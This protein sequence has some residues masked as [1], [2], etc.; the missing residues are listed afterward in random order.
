ME[1]KERELK[2][3]GQSP[4]RVDA[5]EKVTGRTS[6]AVDL[7]F[8]GMLH[9][10]VVRSPHAHA[11]IVFMDTRKARQTPG[12]VS[13]VTGED[14]PTPT[15]VMVED[16][17]FLARKKVRFIGDPVAAVA[18]VDL[19]AAEEALQ[20]IEVEYE[21]LPALFDPLEAMKPGAVLIHE[22][23]S[24][25]DLAPG[26]FPVAG[27]NICNHFKI[28]KGDVEEGFAK[29]DIVLEDTYKTQMVQHAHLEPHAAIAQV[30]L[31]GRVT[32]WS[33]TQ[34]PYFNR[35]AVARALGLPFNK[36]RLV[37][38]PIG[39]GFGGKI[40]L[41]AEPICVA[42]SLKARGRPVRLVYTREEEFEA[43]TVRHP[44]RIRCKS[45]MKNDGTWLAQETELIFD[46]GAYADIGPR[47]NRSAGL[48][49]TGPYVIPNVKV[50]SYCVY[51]NQPVGGAFR[52]FGIP[53]VTWAAESH[54][55][56]VA[57]ELG[58]D[59]VEIRMRNAVG[60]GSISAT[61]QVFHSVGLKET[62]REAVRSIGWGKDPRP[63]RG[64]GIAC[65]HKPTVTPSSSAAFVKLNEDASVTV[66]CSAVELGQG[67]STTLG[68]IASEELGIPID[69]IYVCPADT[70]T[71][72]YDMATVAS[73]STFFAGN[74]VRQAAADARRQLL[75]IAS[76][77]LKV[78]PEEL[79]VQNGI[80]VHAHDPGIAIP[81]ANLPLGEAYYVGV[82]KKGKGRPILGRG[83]HTVEASTAL[84]RE[85][86]Q[87]KNPSAFWMYATQAAEVEVDPLTGKVKVLRIAAAHDM[88]KAIHPRSCEGQI[89]GG[90]MMGIG[91]TL[92]EEMELEQGKVRNPNFAEYKIPSALDGAEMIPILVEE[93]HR[94]GPYGAKG[95][96]EPA[97]APTAAAIANAIEAAVGVRITTLPITPEKILEGLSKK[98]P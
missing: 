9:A 63:F 73:R 7:T 89:Q 6:F 71:T 52:G 60:E 66:L 81:I 76:G 36:V 69:K 18:A 53:Q 37:V 35:N 23:L 14:I 2:T 20:K 78:K 22:D 49:A 84:D 25:Y 75:D 97:L 54:L 39:G 77:I 83:T 62:I 1:N 16:Q 61:G 21:P 95:L 10:K 32:I 92:F 48:A 65:M 56:R 3:V 26:V 96:G 98:C 55:D 94:D 47:V 59:P 34:S 13:V 70:D 31:A 4:V 57:R 93:P 64:K 87:G 79:R 85:T 12:V 74:A 80:V 86:G 28:R 5:Y 43:A 8:P 40:Y 88:G 51:T 42:L 38:T 41:K 30:D 58:L 50:D 72:P 45:G 46:T 33:N 15:G 19:H 11:R 68:Q 44:T 91:T 29:S 82:K 24:H 17:V 90:L 27:T 67:L